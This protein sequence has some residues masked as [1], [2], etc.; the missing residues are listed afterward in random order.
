VL[1]LYLYISELNILFGMENNLYICLLLFAYSMTILSFCIP[2]NITIRFFS[3]TALIIVAGVGLTDPFMYVG[4]TQ[5]NVAPYITSQAGDPARNGEVM[6]S[7]M[8]GMFGGIQLWY[9]A[10]GMYRYA[11]DTIRKR[12]KVNI[13]KTI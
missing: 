2:K 8:Y 10:I 3:A 12:G 13:D 5:T 9:A 11:G 6:S 4:W 1:F 7:R